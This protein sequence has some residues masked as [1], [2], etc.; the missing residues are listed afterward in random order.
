MRRDGPQAAG[1]A[2]H[3]SG[4]QHADKR[5]FGACRH[6]CGTAAPWHRERAIRPLPMSPETC[7]LAA[8][9]VTSRMGALFPGAVPRSASTK[10]PSSGRDANPGCGGQPLFDCITPD[11]LLAGWPLCCPAAACEARASAASRD[12]TRLLDGGVQSFFVFGCL[13]L[14]HP[15]PTTRVSRL[16][17]ICPDVVCAIVW[18]SSQCTMLSCPQQDGK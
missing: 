16:P 2:L 17:S 3:W 10:Q 6:R 15:G 14:L 13:R 12:W 1:R 7:R 11:T 4:Q 9:P 18:P 5:L 8:S